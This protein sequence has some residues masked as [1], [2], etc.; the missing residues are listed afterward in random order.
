MKATLIT[1]MKSHIKHDIKVGWGLL[2]NEGLLW[3]GE[4]KQDGGGE[5]R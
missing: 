1:L 4:G 5:T 2:G 3:K